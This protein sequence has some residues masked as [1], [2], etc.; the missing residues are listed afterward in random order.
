MA[1]RPPNANR[2]G[3]VHSGGGHGYLVRSGRYY[4]VGVEG[5]H[6]L[7]TERWAEASWW[8]H[9]SQARQWAEQNLLPRR[10]GLEVTRVQFP[11]SHGG[12][13]N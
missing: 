10:T 12:R 4:A 6:P 2:V 7:L 8:R 11:T 1:T 9:E 3:D 5:E 13:Q